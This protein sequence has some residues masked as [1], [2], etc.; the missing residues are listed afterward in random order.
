MEVIGYFIDGDSYCV[1]CAVNEFTCSQLRG[2][3]LFED[4]EPPQVDCECS[5]NVVYGSESCCVC[6]ASL[7][8]Y[9]TY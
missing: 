6:S 8:P 4:S 2:G 1:D 5:S 3:E 7:R 9:A